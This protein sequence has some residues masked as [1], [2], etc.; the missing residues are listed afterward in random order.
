M[1][2]D[3]HAMQ[4]LCIS[5]EVTSS[6]RACL[7]LMAAVRLCSPPEAPCLI[8]LHLSNAAIVAVLI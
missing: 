7:I 1:C 4:P 5:D 2:T 6:C 8:W 3:S